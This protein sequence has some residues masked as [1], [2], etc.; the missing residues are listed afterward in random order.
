VPTALVTG[1]L[2]QAADT[3]VTL[4][5]AGF[6]VLAA[7]ADIAQVPPG[8]GPVDC[9]VQLPVDPPAAGGDA[10]AWA[11]SVVSRAL[12]MRFDA[13]AQIA[14]RLAANARVVLVTDPADGAPA[15]DPHVIRLFIA[16]IIADHGGHDVR[17]AVVNGLRHPDELVGAARS[18]PPAWNEYPTVEPHLA[19][20][21]WRTEITCQ[22]SI[23]SWT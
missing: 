10:L 5:A 15:F 12:L 17:V 2:E 23:D 16:A 14:P 22:S 20:S 9:Y 7:Q 11:H 4:K 1:L 6:D 3:A 13:A 8:L 21:D 18:G 19:F